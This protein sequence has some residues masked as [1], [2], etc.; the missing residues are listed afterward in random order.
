MDNPFFFF[1]FVV[2]FNV[3]RES[4]SVSTQLCPVTSSSWSLSCPWS[5]KPFWES[6]PTRGKQCHSISVL[7]R[8]IQV[9]IHPPTPHTPPPPHHSVEKTRY[10]CTYRPTFLGEKEL[11]ITIK[12]ILTYHCLGQHTV[13]VVLWLPLSKD[14]RSA[15]GFVQGSQGLVGLWLFPGQ[16]VRG[17]YSLLT[18]H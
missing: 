13:F 1:Y 12:H 6:I 17:H 9:H 8:V 3:L 18:G 11:T 2:F 10:L 7:S 16:F 5:S 14:N 4:F 15:V